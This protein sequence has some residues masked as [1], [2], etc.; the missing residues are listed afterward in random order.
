M[1]VK[2]S[3]EVRK[4]SSGAVRDNADN[5]P[6]MEL[7]PLDLLMDLSEWYAAGAE[8]YGDNNWLRGQPQSAII[9]SLL[10]HLTK[11]VRGDID[12]RHDL[13]LVWNAIALQSTIKY[14]KDNPAVCDIVG[15]FENGKPTGKGSYENE[16]LHN[17]KKE[18]L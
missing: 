10:R 6:R 18:N 9:G 16:M 5:K 2:S 4:F 13:A 3:G 15:W 1:E 17:T 12:E 14:H 11:L 8:K 7:L